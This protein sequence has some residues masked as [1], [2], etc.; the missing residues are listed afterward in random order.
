MLE[1]LWGAA[2][3]HASD[4][5]LLRFIY[6]QAA[7]TRNDTA[8]ARLAKNPAL[9]ADLGE[10]LDKSAF[11]K[12]LVARMSRPGFGTDRLIAAA[13]DKRVTVRVELASTSGLPAAVYA[14]LLDGP[15]S[16]KVIGAVLA[17]TTIPL[18]TRLAAV[19]IYAEKNTS[20]ARTWRRATRETHQRIIALLGAYPQNVPAV[21]AVANPKSDLTGA[22]LGLAGADE[23]SLRACLERCIEALATTSGPGQNTRHYRAWSE[24]NEIVEVIGAAAGYTDF[25]EDLW[26][27]TKTA[28]GKFPDSREYIVRLDQLR[29][30][31]QTRPP[32]PHVSGGMD[33]GD[34]DAIIGQSITLEDRLRAAMDYDLNDAQFIQ[35]LCTRANT[36]QFQPS[37]LSKAGVE[38]ANELLAKLKGRDACIGV[39][40]ARLLPEQIDTTL[41]EGVDYG[42]CAK[43]IYEE[44]PVAGW[45]E[46]HLGN[47]AFKREWW[48][49]LLL[50]EGLDDKAAASLPAWLADTNRAQARVWDDSANEGLLIRWRAAVAGWLY[51][52][53][54]E[55]VGA[56]SVF[57]KTGTTMPGSLL[58]AVEVVKETIA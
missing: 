44:A 43:A 37:Q 6:G 56:W 58:D 54:G 17:N 52:H 19:K 12:V 42:K 55:D 27:K 25:P 47:H 10:E 1:D 40:G 4:E 46:D 50:K 29:S 16:E 5:S 33:D 51:T 15:V 48:M 11:A 21:L 14:K 20:S 57:D 8:L 36:W 18:A 38:K 22:L 53:L 9:P 26:K 39:L 23:A 34:L 35:V 13:S 45:G 7:K 3:S 30:R 24:F 41:L 49:P 28:L 2:A 31:A 32:V